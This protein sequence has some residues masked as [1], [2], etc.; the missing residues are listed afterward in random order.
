[1]ENIKIVRGRSQTFVINVT[2]Q[3]GEAYTLGSS[4]KLIFG[5]KKNYFDADYLITKT[6]T[7]ANVADSGG[8]TLKIT[9]EDT[10]NLSCGTYCYDV[11]LQSGTDYFTV[12]ECSNFVLAHNVTHKESTT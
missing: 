11:G 8:Y 4:E 1:M 10:A 7:S 6:L 2:D 9:P 5:V 3:D 12:I